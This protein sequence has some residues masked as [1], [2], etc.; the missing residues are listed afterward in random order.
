MRASGFIL[1]NDHDLSLRSSA[2]SVRRIKR[3]Y[4]N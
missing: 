2:G 4:R 3:N 1:G